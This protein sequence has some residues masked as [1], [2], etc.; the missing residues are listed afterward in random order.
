MTGTPRKARRFR[1]AGSQFDP[2]TGEAR[3]SYAFD[4]GPLLTER[5]RFPHAPWPQDQSRQAA[6]FRALNLLHLVAGVSYYKACLPPEID[7][8]VPAPAPDLAGFLETLYEQGLAEFAYVNGLDLC[9]RIRF[10]PG[11]EQADI[12]SDEVLPDRALVAMGGGKDSLLSLELL[13][14]AGLEIQPFC[15][16][17]SAL[18]AATVTA[19]GLPL[20]QVERELAPGLKALNEAGAWNGH[21][22]VTAI[23][24]AIGVCA[25]LLHGFRWVVFSNERSADEA[26]L[27]DAQGRLVNHQYSKSFAF[28]RAFGEIVRRRVA[29]GIGYFSLLRRLSELGV[30]QR[31]SR[32]RHYHPVFSSCNRNFHLDGPRT[33]GRWCGDCPKCRF[34]TLVLAPFL[35]RPEIESIF[36][37][38]LLD[39]DDQMPGFRALARLG[40]DKPFECVGTVAESRAA[41]AALGADPA[42]QDCRVVRGL[43]AAAA[44][45]EPPAIEALLEPQGEHCIP[46][47]VLERV[48]F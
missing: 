7:T 38:N 33:A 21:V 22:P 30:A 14:G 32:L 29:P 39:R 9:G 48:R 35:P 10:E 4:D 13:R 27:T 15:V 45:T 1:F 47:E 19:A 2:A 17:R 11:P 37:C 18:I 24:S 42:W 25:A 44:A 36:G 8:G 40:V 3:L 28:E 5:L 6:F 26:T 43:A 41:L 34:T 16:G 31:F 46:A 20:I 23:N 12:G